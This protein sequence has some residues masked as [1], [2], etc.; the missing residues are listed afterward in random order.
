MTIPRIHIWTSVLAGICMAIASAAGVFSVATYAKESALWAAQGTGQDYVNL[1]LVFPALMIAS[2]F[3]AQGSARALLI[4][5]GLLIYIAYSYVLYSFFVTF[6]PLFLIYIATLGL[7]WYALLGII[8]SIVRN[9]YVP[10]VTRVKKAASIYLCING[11]LFA[12]LWL[13][14]I[15]SSLRSGTIPASGAE[16]GF[17][18][19]PVQ[20]LDLGFIL[21]AMFAVAIMLWKKH[22]YGTVFALPIMIF[23]VVM[24]T[25]ILSMILVMY[26]RGLPTS[27]VPMVIM[28]VN[29][30]VGVILS[31]LFLKSMSH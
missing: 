5:L 21:P 29:V 16:L 19:N 9:N 10:L 7:S 11:V 3:V 12:L 30:T 6:G 8:I 18:V 27:V 20:V 15:V 13:S 28:M 4:Q 24:A 17:I 25:A 14:E 1:L 22:D 26:M 31:S 23:A 2:Y